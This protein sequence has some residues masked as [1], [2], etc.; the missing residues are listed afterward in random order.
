MSYVGKFGSNQFLGTDADGYLSS[1]A[2]GTSSDLLAGD[3]TTVT[4]SST[5]DL[6]LN[7]MSV[8]LSNDPINILNAHEKV[9]TLTGATGTVVHDCSFGNIF[10]H[11]SIGANF[12]AN[13]TNLVIDGEYATSST[14]ILSQGATPYIPNAVEIGGVAQTIN[15]QG[16]SAPSGNANKKDIVS[17]GVINIGSTL[18]PNYVVLGQLSSFG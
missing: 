6:T 2:K 5:L 16:G 18:S 3:G 1:T 15:W 14:L 4:L 7:N 12:T 13:F 11:T 17:F 8:N 10:Y 9:K